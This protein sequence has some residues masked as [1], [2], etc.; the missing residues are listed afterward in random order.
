[1]ALRVEYCLAQAREERAKFFEAK[2]KEK[3]QSKQNQ[4]VCQ[5]GQGGH[6]NHNGNPV[7]QNNG[8]NKREDSYNYNNRN[9]KSQPQK[10]SNT[11]IPLCPKC[12][13]THR[14]ECRLGTNSCYRCGKECHYAKNC[15]SNP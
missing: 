5:K 8:N 7:S 3:A 9:Q 4:D 15:Y 2:K 11:N 12:G 14:R 1:M 6:A 13:K 10:K